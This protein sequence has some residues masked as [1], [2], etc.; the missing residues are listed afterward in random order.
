MQYLVRYI[1]SNSKQPQLLYCTT[2]TYKQSCFQA[3]LKQKQLIFFISI[4]HKL[5]KIN[6]LRIAN[7]LLH[8][9]FSSLVAFVSFYILFN[10]ISKQRNLLKKCL[11]PHLLS[12]QKHISFNYVSWQYL[13]KV[14]TNNKMNVR[15]ES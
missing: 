10:D 8:S 12:F 14:L 6:T 3:K 15:N 1:Y 11:E 9:F 4:T 5:L 13:E 7:C 2:K